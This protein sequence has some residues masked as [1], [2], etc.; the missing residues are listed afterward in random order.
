MNVFHTDSSRTAIRPMSACAGDNNVELGFPETAH[1][2]S[3]S[4]H[5]LSPRKSVTKN[6][7]NLP[8][9]AANLLTLQGRAEAEETTCCCSWI[10]YWKKYFTSSSPSPR[11]SPRRQSSKR[12]TKTSTT[13]M[14]HRKVE[15]L[16]NAWTT[17]SLFGKVRS[18]TLQ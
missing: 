17:L 2:R 16:P 12:E 14:K 18:L 11:T 7:N 15:S 9:V 1:F 4:F 10:M 5:C 3:Q 6:F 8:T 13:F